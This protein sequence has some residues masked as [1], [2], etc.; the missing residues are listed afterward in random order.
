MANNDT[1]KNYKP[2]D[3]AALLAAELRDA[4]EVQAD[5][6]GLKPDMNNRTLII[7][8][9]GT[10]VKTLNHI[11][12]ALKKRMHPDWK[13]VVA[14]L[15]ID[16]S[17]TEI[18][19]ASH[20][21]EHEEGETITRP[22]VDTRMQNYATYPPAVRRFMLDGEDPSTPVVFDGLNTDG[23][24]MTRLIGKLKVHDKEPG[25]PGVDERIVMKLTSA[26]SKLDKM[27]PSVE[28]G[29]PHTYEVY[30]IGSGSGGTGSGAFL[31]IPALVREALRNV[32]N[33]IHIYG[34][35]YM[36]DTLVGLVPNSAGQ[37]KA[38]GYATLKELNYF[39]GLE[40]RTGYTDVWTYSNTANPE[41]KISSD[42]GYF[43]IP[44]LI[45]CPGMADA[46]SSAVSREII[47][48]FLISLLVKSGNDSFVSTA[49]TSN[50]TSA[51]AKGDKPAM[52]GNPNKEAVGTAHEFP[53]CFA[54][55]GFARA[56]APEQVIRAYAVK[57]TIVEAGIKPVS[58]EEITKLTADTSKSYK[59]MPFR[60]IDQLQNADEG[61]DK[62]K[63]LLKPLEKLYGVV[64]NGRFNFV[65][66]LRLPA[67]QVTWENVKQNKF[68][69][70]STQA[71]IDKKVTDK[72]DSKSMEQLRDYISTQYDEYV[73]GVIDYVKDYGPFAFTNLYNGKFIAKGSN[74]GLG[75]KDML[76]NLMDG[77]NMDGKPIPVKSVA[78]AEQE[79]RKARDEVN[80]PP[81]I[82]AVVVKIVT[83]AEKDRVTNNWIKANEALVMARINEKRRDAVKGET[84]ALAERFCRP[85]ALL[86]DDIAAFGHVLNALSDVYGKHGEE[87]AS[88]EEFREATDALTEINVASVD[89]GSYK[90]LVNAVN[91]NV[92]KV[93]ARKFRDELVDSFFNDRSGWL[94][95]P[96][97]TVTVTSDNKPTLVSQDRPVPARQK[98]DQY[99]TEAIELNVDVSIYNLFA[100]AGSSKYDSMAD[101]LMRDLHNKSQIRFNGS[102]DE[103]YVYRYVQYPS[104]LDIMG[105]EGAKIVK[106]LRNAATHYGVSAG[107]VYPSEDTNAVI[108]VQQATA[109]EIFRVNNLAD[110]EAEYNARSEMRTM[111]HGKSPDVFKQISPYGDISYKEGQ[112]WRD[113]P[114]IVY[115]ENHE[116]KDPQ[117]GKLMYPEGELRVALRKE[118]EEAKKLGVLYSEQTP[119]GWVIR[120][121]NCD[122]TRNWE[123]DR[124]LHLDPETGLA[125][126]GKALLEA[127][128]SQNDVPMHQMTRVVRLE[129]AG[130]FSVPASSEEYAWSNAE[131]VL[132]A[133][134]PM[135]CEVRQTVR[136]YFSK[137]DAESREHNQDILKTMRPEKLIPLLKAGIITRNSMGVW[138]WNKADKT[139]KALANFSNIAIKNMVGPA[140]RHL[141]G[142]LTFF[143]L[144]QKVD[145]AMPGETLDKEHDRAVALIMKWIEAMDMK[146]FEATQA[147]MEALEAERQ[148][149]LEKGMIDEKFG[150]EVS[151][152]FVDAMA[153]VEPKEEILVEIQQFYAKM[154]QD[155]V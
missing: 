70:A 155:E 63:E 67:D 121:A 130:L 75:I 85:A 102:I 37:L 90:W 4:T 33:D 104:T 1:L 136:D 148:A 111:I 23:A 21:N 119:T 79:L 15:A 28:G 78:T 133:H 106:A 135:M 126:T 108:F 120:R 20:L 95:I 138:E 7:G 39:Q 141:M 18:Q 64:N 107:N 5:E 99:A 101:A 147:T 49:F 34:I 81:T 94:E 48:E 35:L 6:T 42:K 112:P 97:Q 109:M 87:M 144:F 88:K 30:V 139:K 50:A 129:R 149:L 24:A 11:K 57:K 124:L 123:Y 14:F 13:R 83:Q 55:I 113:Y 82:N 10:G 53:K 91:D 140:K 127:V 59:L 137:W 58:N 71:N 19:G 128:A 25:K 92:E 84:G 9:G 66:D 80:N 16:S 116:A 86:A 103:S 77:K 52:P 114:S 68:S 62:A 96:E 154:N 89:D 131:R 29:A 122:A 51:K 100:Q 26:L 73:K 3:L 134:H 38:N 60:G 61:T 117:T 151:Q 150:T 146:R 2:D 125:P 93:N 46:N 45:G 22:G 69:N 105:E 118:I 142:G 110:W 56:T 31:E 54:S 43:T 152:D 12:G 145:A 153:A 41:L 47:A 32:S 17:W 27:S 44:Y 36:P 65:A 8:I 115:R 40:T 74:F 76:R 98:F 72:T 143:E 132:R